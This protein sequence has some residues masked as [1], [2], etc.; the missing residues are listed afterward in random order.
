MAPAWV[1]AAPLPVQVARPR[2]SRYRV[3][4]ALLVPRQTA[5]ATRTTGTTTGGAR[6]ACGTFARV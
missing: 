4:R 2:A 3:M 6:M 1:L 5:K